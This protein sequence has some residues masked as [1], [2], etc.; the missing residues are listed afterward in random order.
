MGEP[1]FRRRS[2]RQFPSSRRKELIRVSR[3]YSRSQLPGAWQIK[4]EARRSCN[5]R[6]V[7]DYFGN[8]DGCVGWG[9]WVLRL[10]RLDAL[11]ESEVGISELL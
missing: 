1:S 11:G 10:I 2:R 5:E 8:F 9:V 4:D 7:E 6:A 3:V